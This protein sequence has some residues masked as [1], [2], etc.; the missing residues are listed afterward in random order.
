MF[1]TSTAII[2]IITS[3]KYYS[4]YDDKSSYDIIIDV[5]GLCPR[6]LILISALEINEKVALVTLIKKGLF[7]H[8]VNHLS[9]ITLT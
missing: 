5:I 9:I 7:L 4:R 3:K 2:Y 6:D 8:L 1:N